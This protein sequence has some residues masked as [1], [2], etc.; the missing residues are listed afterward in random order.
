MKTIKLLRLLINILY[1]TLI[2]IFVLYILFFIGIF[3]YKDT[4]PLYLQGYKMLFSFINWKL[5]LVPLVTVINYILFVVSIYYLRKCIQPFI[6]AD[7]YSLKVIK[8]LKRAGKIF[9]F[10]GTSMIVLKM[11]APFLI[12]PNIG[13]SSG[14]SIIISIASALDIAMISLIIIGLFLLL[15]SDSFK[16]AREIQEENNL[17]I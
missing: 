15:F 5:L 8:N 12:Q 2:S 10:I 14:L 4:L 7:F 11:T 17:T 16:N 13:I 6:K 3:I 1:F 9:I